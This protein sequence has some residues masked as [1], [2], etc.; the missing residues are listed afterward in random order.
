MGGC[1]PRTRSTV[2]PVTQSRSA[3]LA[4]HEY[5]SIVEG[6]DRRSPV[7]G[8][9]VRVTDVDASVITAVE[10]G[11][12]IRTEPF[13]VPSV[14]RSAVISDPTGA[15][16]CLWQADARK[17]AQ[18]VNEPGAWAMSMLHTPDADAAIVFYGAVFGWQ[19]EP[20]GLAALFRLPGYVGGEEQQLVPRDVVAG[21]V[22]DDQP[23]WRVDFWVA[24]ARAASTRAAELG[25]TVT[26]EPY[27][28]PGFLQAVL[29]DPQAASF[30]IS[31]LT[32]GL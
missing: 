31:Q 29:T 4:P 17:G 15:V 25:G 19:P 20:L 18:A 24:H 28:I 13:E 9:H 5:G 10:A 16:V 11:G 12:A 26:V 6:M 22:Q 2:T 14:G 32:A 30:S 3:Q 23:F 1:Q 27:E 21:M 7:W 8:T